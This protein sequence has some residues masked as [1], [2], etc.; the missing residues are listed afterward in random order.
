MT[1]P[2]TRYARTGDVSLAYTVVGDGP[3]DILY[4]PGYIS[5]V[6]FAFDHPRYAGFIHQLAAFGRVIMVDRRG[7]GC[8]DRFSPEDLPPL[9]TLVDDLKVLLDEV[10]STRTALLAFEAGGLMATMF[11]ATYPQRTSA[12]ILYGNSPCGTATD[13]YPWQWAS[14]EWEAYFADVATN[15]GTDEYARRLAAW[16]IPT[17]ADDEGLVRWWSRFLRLSASPM[18]AV[19]IERLYANTDMR[20]VLP[21][22]HVPTLVLHRRGDPAE[23]IESSVYTAKHIPGA[24][25]VELEGVDAPPWAGDSAAIVAEIEQFL[26]GTRHEPVTERVLATLLFTDIVGSTAHQARLGDR[27][28][29]TLVERHHAI[30]REH[31]G[32]F[33]GTEVDTAGDGFFATFDGPARAVR[34]AQAITQATSP[35]GLEIRSGVHTGEVETVNEKV[36]GIAVSIGARVAALAAPGEVLVSST[37]KDLVAGSGLVFEGTGEHELKGVP[38]RW[39][40]Y[41]VIS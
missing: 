17:H 26:T 28:W 27:D 32:R 7:T 38:D 8:S 20:D 35:I 14:D 5:N 2:Q 3:L 1:T 34:C 31:L 23:Q 30:V 19:A 4:I 15:W 41:R 40:L 33:R 25:L 18:G 10:G 16:V 21:S 6:E 36:G 37:V 12:L 13:D 9:E 29:R 39:R 24:R 22:V 11:A